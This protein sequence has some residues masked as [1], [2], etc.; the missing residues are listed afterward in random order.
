[1]CT[2]KL[3][4]FISDLK[5]PRVTQPSHLKSKAQ[6]NSKTHA[7]TDFHALN[8]S[9]LTI[10]TSTNQRLPHHFVAFMR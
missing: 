10:L 3:F 1:M 9:D 8:Q 7:L 6:L 5:L 2:C 4:A